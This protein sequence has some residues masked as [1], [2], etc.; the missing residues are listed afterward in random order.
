M[1][2]SWA[3]TRL[4]AKIL[5]YGQSRSNFIILV[6]LEMFCLINSK[7]PGRFSIEHFWCLHNIRMQAGL[8]ENMRHTKYN[9]VGK[10]QG[11]GLH[12]GWNINFN[13]FLNTQF[14]LCSRNRVQCGLR[15]R[16]VGCFWRFRGEID[17]CC[18]VVTDKTWIGKVFF[19]FSLNFV[20]L[21]TSRNICEGL[22]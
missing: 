16:E 12:C 20:I 13:S 5:L 3:L 8:R 1:T 19:F 6:S 18:K 11:L 21:N 17:T 7:F 2:S 9:W 4:V 14:L 22:L 15:N 10:G